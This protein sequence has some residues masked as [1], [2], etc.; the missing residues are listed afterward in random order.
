MRI[1]HP[2]EALASGDLGLEAQVV[3]G[4]P[5]PTAAAP[6]GMLLH[7]VDF[8]AESLLVAAL[9]GELGLVLANVVARAYFRQ[10]FLWADEAARLALSVLAFVGGA[11][12]LRRP[13]PRVR[14]RLLHLTS[15]R[16]AMPRL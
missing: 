1:H 10:S 8:L 12:A 11:G 9:I 5:A 6:G 7:G 3:S 13:G 2:I 16:G 4:E 15:A 14:R